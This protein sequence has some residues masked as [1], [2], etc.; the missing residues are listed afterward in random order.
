VKHVAESGG[1]GNAH[2]GSERQRTADPDEQS[3]LSRMPIQMWQR[4]Q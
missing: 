4:P 3:M 2:K 1:P